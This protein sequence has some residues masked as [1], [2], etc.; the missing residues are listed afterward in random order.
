MALSMLPDNKETATFNKMGNGYYYSTDF[1][2]LGNSVG[3]SEKFIARSIDVLVSKMNKMEVLVKKSFLNDI[4][5]QQ[6]ID[7]MNNRKLRLIK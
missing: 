6:F 7:L 1:L 2:E 4:R 5:K 3:L